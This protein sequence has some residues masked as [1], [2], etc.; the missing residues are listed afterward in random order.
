MRFVKLG[1]EVGCPSRASQDGLPDAHVAVDIQSFR[2]T[3][4]GPEFRTFSETRMNT[5]SS[6]QSRFLT[7]FAPISERGPWLLACLDRE[8]IAFYAISQSFS[9]DST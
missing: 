3:L 6:M 4:G 9:K 8:I 1:S 7:D 2:P 5:A